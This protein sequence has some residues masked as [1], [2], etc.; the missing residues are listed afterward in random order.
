MKIQLQEKEECP[1]EG[2]SQITN[3]VYKYDVGKILPTKIFWNCRGRAEN[4][5]S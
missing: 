3:I 4:V 5:F 1:M 2:N